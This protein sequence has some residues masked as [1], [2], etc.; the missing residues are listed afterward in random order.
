M[1]TITKSWKGTESLW[2][3]FWIHNTLIGF[4]VEKIAEGLELNGT[5]WLY[6]FLS[7][8]SVAWAIWASVSLWRCAFN[9]S[10]R[11]WGYLVR[12]ILSLIIVLILIAFGN[13]IQF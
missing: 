12:L 13:E 3:V 2:I 1:N 8:L 9:S 10:W 6:Y 7:A 11:G 4:F 5:E